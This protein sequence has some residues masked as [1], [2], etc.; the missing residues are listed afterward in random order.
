MRYVLRVAVL[1]VVVGSLGAGCQLGE[2][3]D[4]PNLEPNT[5]I[6]EGY[7]NE[8]QTWLSSA[9]SFRFFGADPDNEIVAYHTK[10]EPAIFIGIDPGNGEEVQVWPGEP[11]Y[12]EGTMDF[13]DTLWFGDIDCWDPVSESVSCDHLIENADG[14]II[15]PDSV[16]SFFDWERTETQNRNYQALFDALYR[17]SVKAVDEGDR[18]DPYPARRH[19][20]VLAATWPD[21]VVDRCPPPRDASPREYMEFHGEL[22]SL[23]PWEFLYSCMLLSDQEPGQCSLCHTFTD[24]QS[25]VTQVSYAGLQ[26][27]V[28]YTFRVKCAVERAGV[29]I[30]SRGYEECAFTIRS[31]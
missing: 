4:R 14:R 27:G 17:F 26:P 31:K 30:E 25:G 2:R 20:L 3:V 9:A 19:F 10:L 22:G 11:A 6:E 28:T 15:P 12:S 1:A 13:V 23:E 18:E 8:N 24:W 21:I 7:P 16:I 5:F 29:T